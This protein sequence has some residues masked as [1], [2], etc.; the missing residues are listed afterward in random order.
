M[1]FLKKFITIGMLA[2]LAVGS[3]ACSQDV[4]LDIDNLGTKI[5]TES[6]PYESVFSEWE[7]MTV[8]RLV[9]RVAQQMNSTYPYT[10]TVWEGVDFKWKT[11]S[12]FPTE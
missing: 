4:K 10:D 7:D 6:V 9:K 1:K 12:H 8:E 5:D 11:N 2:A 3:V